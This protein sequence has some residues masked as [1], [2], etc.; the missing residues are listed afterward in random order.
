MPLT[1]DIFKRRALICRP[2]LCWPGRTAVN[3]FG[4]ALDCTILPLTR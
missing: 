3:S 4:Q 1:K 2:R